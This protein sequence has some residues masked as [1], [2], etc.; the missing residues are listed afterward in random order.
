MRIAPWM[1]VLCLALFILAPQ[2]QGQAASSEPTFT[3]EGTT[4]K[5]SI[6]S[7]E[8]HNWRLE[9]FDA[10]TRELLYDSGLV[11]GE[12]RLAEDELAALASSQRL[13]YELRAWD[14]EGELLLSQVSSLPDLGGQL[15]FIDFE[16]IPAGVKLLGGQITL[17]SNVE[18]VGVLDAPA[19]RTAELR[20]VGGGAFFGTCSAGSSIRSIGP[21]GSVTCEVVGTGG[22]NLGNHRATQDILFDPQE[23]ITATGGA[24]LLTGPLGGTWFAQ[25][26]AS[27]LH[28]FGVRS[29]DA[30]SSNLD[31]DFVI[32]TDGNVGIFTFDPVAAL[33]VR[34]NAR[35]GTGD[36]AVG[37]GSDGLNAFIQL[38]GV[39]TPYIDFQN[40]NNQGSDF[41]MR[42]IL[43]GDDSLTLDGGRLGI[44][45]TMT[46]P[47]FKLDLPNNP[48]PDGQGR[49]NAWVVYSSARHKT[50]VRTL[51]DA[52]GKLR[53]L[54]GVEFNWVAEPDGSRDLGFIAE[55]VGAVLPELVTW[56]DNGVD[57]KSLSY[58]GVIPV[59]VEALK[60]QLALLEAQGHRIATLEE[61]V[62]AAGAE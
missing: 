61:K 48:G 39:G 51:P 22:D 42:L 6:D 27:G 38:Q 2:L 14:A 19:V 11:V 5:L 59:L 56:E 13:R 21:D 57:A 52:L 34:G 40:D 30:P 20:N 8:I 62:R 16:E 60:E 18:V 24:R 10:T 1:N 12:L 35:I 29:F 15:F 45:G 41:D 37:Q 49:A 3:T 32:D 31:A 9:A 36:D 26:G 4:L 54:R 43:S 55:E 33:D 25:G 17:E 7:A 46:N 28:R 44:G 50:N 58:D 53:R 47:Q 23:G